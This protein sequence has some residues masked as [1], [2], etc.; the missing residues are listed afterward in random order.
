MTETGGVGAG[1]GAGAEDAVAPSAMS[2]ATIEP[3]AGGWRLLSHDAVTSTNDVAKRL[4]REGAAHGTV[5]AARRQ[6]AGRG[7]RGR[8]WSSPEG[9]VYASV[10]LRPGMPADQAAQLSFV[11]AVATAQALGDLLPGDLPVRCKWPNDVLIDGAKVSG[12]LLETE[13]GPAG[14]IE[15]I[16]LGIGINVL[17]HPEPAAGDTG[18]PVTSLAAR[19]AT[20]TDPRNVL[21][22]VVEAFRT[23]YGRWM[24]QG[25]AP[26]R[27]NWL[28][29][30]YGIGGPVTVRLEHAT[31][32]GRFAGLDADG[33]L[34]LE[35]D[36]AAIHRIKAGDVFFGIRSEGD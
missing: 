15:W 1:A 32:H 9:N 8:S 4:A 2:A 17:H 14:G 36:G 19:G 28:A 18:Y 21:G 24:A 26:V 16:V 23:W 34:L 3:L 30:A 27:A 20:Q 12:I 35:R 6:E 22:A 29:A 5:V 31:L 7:R 13:T 33:A 10:V 11:A 25:F